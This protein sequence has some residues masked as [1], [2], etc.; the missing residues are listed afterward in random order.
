M[1]RYVFLICFSVLSVSCSQ[2]KQLMELELYD[3]TY[4]SG[5]IKELDAERVPYSVEGNVIKYKPEYS[6]K[7]KEAMTRVNTSYAAMYKVKDKLVADRFEKKLSKE[8]IPYTVH[9]DDKGNAIFIIKDVYHVKASKLLK[10]AAT[11]K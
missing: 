6:F 7:V 5:L 9:P 8:E 11:G 4:K 10:E 1:M 2:S 3:E